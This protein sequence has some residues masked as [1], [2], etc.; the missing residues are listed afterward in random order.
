MRFA[1][2]LGALIACVTGINSAK[3]DIVPGLIGSFTPELSISTLG[4]GPELDARF[5]GAP[6]GLR[7]AA[8]FFST[9]RNFSSGDAR[10]RAKADLQ[11]GGFTADWY[12]LLSGLRL[13][14]GLKV[15]DNNATVS[16]LPN[17]AG[18]FTV[19]HVT[20]ATA[21]STVTG[22]VTFDR[23]APYVGLGYSNA[24]LRSLVLGLD[25][26]VMVQ[27]GPKSALTASGLITNLPGFGGNLAQ[28]Q[29]SLQN[30][31]KNYSYYPV[32]EVTVGW[33]F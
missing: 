25:A 24:V 28:E 27:G 1:G 9:N 6:I 2:G 7:I 14:A 22:K 23:M 29:Q 8:N 20:Y 15:N 17:A 11:S 10:Y 13:S 19:N 18:S 32:I 3:A 31:I 30:K 4:I 5:T 21:G 12:P 26:G 33:Q 16:S